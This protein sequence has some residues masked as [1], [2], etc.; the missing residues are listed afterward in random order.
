MTLEL[1]EDEFNRLSHLKDTTSNRSQRHTQ[2]PFEKKMGILQAIKEHKSN[3]YIKR[4]FRT[5]D[6]TII[7]IKKQNNL[8]GA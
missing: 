5:S 1:T 4:E 8:W 2:L 3:E 6:Y 7:K